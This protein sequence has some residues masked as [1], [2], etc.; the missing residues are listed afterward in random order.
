MRHRTYIVSMMCIAAIL[1]GTVFPPYPGSADY[2]Q[3]IDDAKNRIEDYGNA[4]EEVQTILAGLEEQKEDA[5]ALIQEMDALQVELSEHLYNLEL[6]LAET[7]AKLAEAEERLLQADADGEKQYADMKRRIQYMYEVGEVSYLDIFLSAGSIAEMYNQVMYIREV[8]RYDREKLDEYEA[9]VQTIADT[10]QELEHTRAELL[11][12]QTEYQTNLDAVNAVLEEKNA[13]LAALSVQISSSIETIGDYEQQIADENAYVAELEHLMEQEAEAARQAAIEA[14]ARAAEQA[15]IEASISEAE[16]IE[17]SIQQSI[18]ESI[19]EAADQS[20][21]SGSSALDDPAETLPDENESGSGGD[22]SQS[23]SS[24]ETGGSAENVQLNLVWPVPCSTRVTSYFGP[25][26]D[27]PIA[28][29][30]LFHNAIDIAAPKGSDI[31]AAADG[32][33]IYAGDGVETNSS[34]GGYQVWIS[35]GNGAYITMYLH[36][37]VLIAEK[38]QT[39]SAGDVIA[40]VG[41]TGLSVGNH[42]DFRILYGSNYIDPL[43]DN[44][45]YTYLQ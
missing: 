38:G 7:E 13:Q 12:Q 20:A 4:M 22:S 15:R 40:L 25:R 21:A 17:A 32:V 23:G 26:P 18:E 45:F 28:G 2:Q 6:T 34:S 27:A 33:V 41:N 19:K 1:C 24:G 11:A 9:T 37:S 31:V 35:H 16:S 42:L 30:A 14:A 36:C 8:N 29:V 10:K 39:V 3:D 44:I 5:A 43:G